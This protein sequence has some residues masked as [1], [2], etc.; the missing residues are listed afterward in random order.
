MYLYV[1][2]FM[3]VKAE[4]EEVFCMVQMKVWSWKKC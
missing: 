3:N 1:I 4:V 2:V